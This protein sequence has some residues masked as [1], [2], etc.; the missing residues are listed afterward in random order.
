MDS[1]SSCSSVSAIKSRTFGTS[2]SKAL[3]LNLRNGVT[4]FSNS[5]VG[6]SRVPPMGTSGNTQ[7]KIVT[8]E[9]GYVLEDVPH[10]IDYIPDLPVWNLI[11]F[12]VCI[13]LCVC[14]PVERERK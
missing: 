10:L 2:D 6:S 11:P 12:D 1:I 7:P 9:N 14:F 13:E 3:T 8:G 5:K 4:A